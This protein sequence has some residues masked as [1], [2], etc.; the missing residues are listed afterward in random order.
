MQSMQ[1]ACHA[2]ESDTVDLFEDTESLPENVRNLLAR[3]DVLFG[4]ECSYKCCREMLKEMERL[5]YTFEYGLEGEPYN[6]EI[7]VDDSQ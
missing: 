4:E 1:R 3:Y 7:L 5:G 2:D 6:L